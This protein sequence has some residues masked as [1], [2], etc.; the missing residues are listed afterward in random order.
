MSA[1]QDLVTTE[2]QRTSR[3]IEEAELRVVTARSE[4]ARQVIDLEELRVQ[5]TELEGHAAEHGWELRPPERPVMNTT[6][7]SGFKPSKFGP[8]DD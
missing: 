8:S 7:T 3:R 4:L 1:A 6:V 2:W 5:K